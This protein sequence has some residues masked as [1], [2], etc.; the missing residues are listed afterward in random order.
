[1]TGLSGSWVF[2]VLCE[3]LTLALQQAVS[4][5]GALQLGLHDTQRLARGEHGLAVL[6]TSSEWTDV[7]QRD[8]GAQH[9]PA[10]DIVRFLRRLDLYIDKTSGFELRYEAE[11]RQAEEGYSIAFGCPGEA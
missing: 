2:C 3:R 7:E 10:P 8:A 9:T 11:L 6:A 1:M 4:R 5:L